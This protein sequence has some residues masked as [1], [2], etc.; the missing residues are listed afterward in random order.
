MLYSQ[1]YDSCSFT[2]QQTGFNILMVVSKASQHGIMV[3]MDARGP[4][5]TF[6]PFTKAYGF[7]KI[8]GI[9][10]SDDDWLVESPVETKEVSLTIVTAGEVY[11]YADL[12][13]TFQDVQ[14]T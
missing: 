10:L 8:L 6:K 1:L 9:K 12:Q 7:Q 13:N 3:Q 2:I 11:L 4:S 5:A 14:T